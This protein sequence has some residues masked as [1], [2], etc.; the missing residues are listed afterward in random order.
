MNLMGP[1]MLSPSVAFFLGGRKPSRLDCAKQQREPW[2]RCWNTYAIMGINVIVEMH[3]RN[4]GDDRHHQ[5]DLKH[6]NNGTEI[7][8]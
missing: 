3:V 4:N 2:S 1:P 6:C 5:N 7:I 8:V